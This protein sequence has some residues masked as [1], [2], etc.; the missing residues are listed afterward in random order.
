MLEP[1]LPLSH[2][3]HFMGSSD[4]MPLEEYLEKGLSWQQLA[5]LQTFAKS[6]IC[7]H[8]NFD[9]SPCNFNVPLCIKRTF[10]K[11]RLSDLW[12]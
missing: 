9:V 7:L 6:C 5:N 1:P 11:Y 8:L 4:K 10:L 2:M 12:K 3:A